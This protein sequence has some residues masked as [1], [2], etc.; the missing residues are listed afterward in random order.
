MSESNFYLECWFAG[1]VQGV[2]FR[3]R[4]SQIAKK[5]KVTGRVRNLEDRRVYLEAEG[6]EDQLL[7]FKKAIETQMQGF[8]DQDKVV[9][10]ITRRLPVFKGFK[11][12]WRKH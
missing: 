1:R 10:N 12:L 5:F 7:A 3:Y 2:G 4:I 6:P 8:I 11:I 9:S